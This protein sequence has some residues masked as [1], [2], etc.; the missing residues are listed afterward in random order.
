MIRRSDMLK[1]GVLTWVSREI[2]PYFT[3]SFRYIGV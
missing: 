2:V 1:D 3:V